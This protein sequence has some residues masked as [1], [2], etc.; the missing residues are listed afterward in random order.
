MSRK[1][2]KTRQKYDKEIGLL[3]KQERKNSGVSQGFLANEIGVSFQQ[4]QKYEEGKDRISCGTL[5]VIAETLG[6][7]PSSF[8]HNKQENSITPVHFDKDTKRLVSYFEAV[9]NPKLKK[10]IIQLC[11]IVLKSS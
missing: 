2:S 11:A 4:V 3:V 10:I 9:D 6:I 5:L 7:S 1:G 8:F